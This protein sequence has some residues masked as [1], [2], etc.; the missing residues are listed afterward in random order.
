MQLCARYTAGAGPRVH[1]RLRQRRS[2]RQ[3]AGPPL[4]HPIVY[5]HFKPL[6]SLVCFK[7]A[8]LSQPKC[9]T[10]QSTSNATVQPHLTVERMN[11]NVIGRVERMNTNV[12]GRDTCTEATL[13]ASTTTTTS[14]AAAAAAA[15]AAIGPI[16]SSS[17][18]GGVK[19]PPRR[20]N[21]RGKGG[22]QTTNH[23]PP[24]AASSSA[25]T[26]DYG[27]VI[28]IIIIT[29]IITT[30]TMRT[31]VVVSFRRRRWGHPT[32]HSIHLFPRLT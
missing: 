9:T 14:A 21:T 16:C 28:I 31:V 11:T 15:A 18:G 12:I 8:S 10:V 24:A 29:T 23:L 3:V 32:P 5:Y 26:T 13:T 25:P 7:G 6:S 27:G 19:S 20:C 1:P 30:T 17:V 4:T 2:R 22:D